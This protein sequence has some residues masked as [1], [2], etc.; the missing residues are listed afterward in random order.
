M[1]DKLKAAVEESLSEGKLTPEEQQNLTKEW[2][3][4]VD[5]KSLKDL[6]VPEF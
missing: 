3:D 6:E 1:I 5:L 4:V 2:Q